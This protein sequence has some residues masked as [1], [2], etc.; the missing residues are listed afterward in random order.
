MTDWEVRENINPSLNSQWLPFN[1]Q[2]FAMRRFC[3]LMIPVCFFYTNSYT[4]DLRGFLLDS[5]THLK[6]RSVRVSN[7]R[8]QKLVY[9]N[10]NGFFSID[11][12][13]NDTIIIR[14]DGYGT[15]RLVYSPLFND[16]IRLYLAPQIKL[17]PGVSVS[18][19]YNQ[20]QQD[21]MIRKRDFEQ[22]RGG[23]L[24]TVSRAQGFGVA[25]NLDKV[26][27]KRYKY[28]RKNEKRFR[29]REKDAYIAYRYSPQLV[30]QYSGLKGE[31]LENFINRHT[32]S[33]EWLRKHAS[34]DDIFRYINEHL[35]LFR[36]KSNVQ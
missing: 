20:Y 8:T 3:F 21:S 22:I 12:N 29:Q 5:A 11:V 16:T 33:Y 4:Q 28:Q 17:L 18:S 23:R 2:K 26:F 19:R 34:D 15:R 27:K 9:S 1:D 36:S 13:P 24:S 30:A 7:T 25:I 35:K 32:P 10:S 14:L 31:E 6:I